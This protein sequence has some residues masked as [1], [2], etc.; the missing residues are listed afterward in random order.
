MQQSSISLNKYLRIEDNPY[1]PSGLDKIRL[2]CN[3]DINEYGFSQLKLVLCNLNWYNTKENAYEKLFH[4][5]YWH[6]LTWLKERIKRPVLLNFTDSEIEIN[7]VLA[8]VLRDLYDIRLPETIQLSSTSVQDIYTLLKQQIA[9]NNSGIEL[10]LIDKPRIKLIHAQAKMT[11]AQYLRR[12]KKL[13]QRRSLR[14]LSYSYS[15]ENFQPYGLEMFKIISN[16]VL[17]RWN[18]W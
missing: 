9:D 7:P 5:Y 12:N 6:L 3:K 4:P 2:E 15:P 18:I 17:H 1:I 8:N 10:N 11:Y 14:S 16:P 13:E